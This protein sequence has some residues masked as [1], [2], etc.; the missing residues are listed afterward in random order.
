MSCGCYNAAEEKITIGSVQVYN[1]IMYNC[2]LQTTT[3]HD[4]VEVEI[5]VEDQ[6]PLL[7]YVIIEQSHT[8]V[9]LPFFINSLITPDRTSCSVL[10]VAQ[11]V[12]DESS[13]SDFDILSF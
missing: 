6:H 4:I 9:L 12:Q 3:S 2:I 7:R 5:L 8:S 10:P 11:D 1:V 13:F